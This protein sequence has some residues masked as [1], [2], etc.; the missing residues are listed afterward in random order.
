[1]KFTLRDRDLSP[2]G[3]GEAELNEHGLWCGEMREHDLAPEL[4]RLLTEYEVLINDQTFV[5]ADRVSN[6]IDSYGLNVVL[7]DG[8]TMLATDLFLDAGGG[9]SW[10][11]GDQVC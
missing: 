2:V 10:M 1:M 3:M 8:R 9:V 4:R 5:A 6:C 11:D 7:E